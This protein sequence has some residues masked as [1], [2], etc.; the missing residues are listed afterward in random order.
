MASASRSAETVRHTARRVSCLARK[1][2]RF[3]RR[4]H[5][6]CLYSSNRSARKNSVTGGAGF[7]GSSRVDAEARSPTS[8]LC[9]RQPASSRRRL[10][11]GRLRDGASVVHGDVAVRDLADAG[12]FDLRS[13][14]RQSRTPGMKAARLLDPDEPRGRALP[15]G[16][17][18]ASC[19]RDLSI[20]ELC[21]SDQAS[22]G[23][24]ARSACGQVGYP[25]RVIR[26]GVV[27]RR[28]HG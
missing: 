18:P 28:N 23:A 22:A 4:Y 17:A 20:D 10:A 21:L 25:G 15:R 6:G 1:D 24:A 9:I 19:G 8:G 5:G 12:P 26:T 7:V 3:G 2:S 27:V 13:S 11:L 16:G 14:A